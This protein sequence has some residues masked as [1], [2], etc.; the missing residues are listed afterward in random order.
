MQSNDIP[1]EVVQTNDGR[2][3]AVPNAATDS[4]VAIYFVAFWFGIIAIMA[5]AA[6]CWLGYLRY[7]PPVAVPELQSKFEEHKAEFNLLVTMIKED[8]TVFKEDKVNLSIYSDGSHLNFYGDGLFDDEI[9]GQERVAQHLALLK[10]VGL[11]TSDVHASRDSHIRIEIFPNG[12]FSNFI[13]KGYLYTT[14][15]PEHI[16]LGF[17]K[18]DIEKIGPGQVLHISLGDNWYISIER[19]QFGD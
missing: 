18:S 1:M 8:F 19:W 12:G 4:N 6:W 11:A 13:A 14:V 3:S 17:E 16:V 5:I 2:L 15:K 7:T 9:I 10:K